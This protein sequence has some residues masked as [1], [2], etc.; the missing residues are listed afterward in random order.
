M[1]AVVRSRAVR[2]RIPLTLLALTDGE[3]VGQV[4]IKIEE[5]YV[6]EGLSPWIGGLLVKDNWRGRGTGKALL[7]EVERVAAELEVEVMYLTC[8][9]DAEPFYERMGWR[10]LERTVS[11]GDEVAV[12]YKNLA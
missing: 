10:V 5:P 3:L 7:S 9:A 8:E 11:L 12:M 2:D 4:S 6:I 1:K